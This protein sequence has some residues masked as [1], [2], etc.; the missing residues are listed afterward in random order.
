MRRS[1]LSDMPPQPTAALPGGEE[2]LNASSL[3]PRSSVA[4][5][6][7]RIKERASN[8]VVGKPPIKENGGAAPV[9]GGKPP[10]ALAKIETPPAVLTAQGKIGSLAPAEPRQ[11][12]PALE[13]VPVISPPSIFVPIGSQLLSLEV[14]LPAPAPLPPVEH[15]ST[16]DCLRELMA[17]AC[18][19]DAETAA[20]ITVF[21]RYH[22]AMQQQQ[23][24]A[25]AMATAR[26]SMNRYPP[27]PSSAVKD[28]AGSQ[29][30]AAIEGPAKVGSDA[31]ALTGSV[32]IA[33]YT[34][35]ATGS[36]QPGGL[37]LQK[38]A[39]GSTYETVRSEGVTVSAKVINQQ[40]QQHQQVDIGAAVAAAMA[41][42]SL[43]P[44]GDGTGS[45]VLSLTIPPH[46]LPSGAVR[47]AVQLSVHI[48]AALAPLLTSS[49]A[50]EAIASATGVL[51]FCIPRRDAMA[52]VPSVGP[53]ASAD[54]VT[55]LKSLLRSLASSASISE[56]ER[57]AGALATSGDSNDSISLLRSFCRVW[58][59]AQLTPA[60][61]QLRVQALVAR[62]REEGGGFEVTPPQP[63]LAPTRL[64]SGHVS[65][66]HTSANITAPA[67]YTPSSKSQLLMTSPLRGSTSI[68]SAMTPSSSNRG[69]T[70]AMAH[71][72]HV[73]E[74][75]VF[76]GTQQ[77]A[78]AHGGAASTGPYDVSGGTAGGS[79]GFST[80]VK[81]PHGSSSGARAG[82][83]LTT[84]TPVVLGSSSRPGRPMVTF[85]FTGGG[86][87]VSP[88]KGGAHGPTASAAATARVRFSANG[89]PAATTG[90]PHA[91]FSASGGPRVLARYVDGVL[92]C[93]RAGAS[94]A[95]FDRE[96]HRGV[97]QKLEAGLH[98]MSAQR[99]AEEEHMRTHT[100][101]KPAKHPKGGYWYQDICTGELLLCSCIAFVRRLITG[102]LDSRC[103]LPHGCNYT[104]LSL[105][106][107]VVFC[108]RARGAPARLRGGVPGR[109]GIRQR[110]HR[111]RHQRGVGA[112]GH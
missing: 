61:S 80:P 48:P 111:K 43:K 98:A 89:S 55:T 84:V 60:Q 44:A 64:G 103:F 56:A 100:G 109:G 81:S 99:R 68:T 7:R 3:K 71:H 46:T 15:M 67:A 59:H 57:I 87:F 52:N 105:L 33:A 66:A 8:L 30:A 94:P 69:R 77:I 47:P 91:A 1:S 42:P 2:N 35:S 85:T 14:R 25:T 70:A 21:E 6:L 76:A 23:Q 50:A 16:H 41:A 20:A 65:V 34:S 37:T 79:Y 24:R 36:S 49:S 86:S 95:S 5:Q 12:E 97:L 106:H 40:A 82:A 9:G 96:A 88:R 29:L 107:I 11:D 18:Q 10:I 51:A 28:K 4:E 101:I 32:S 110:L 78:S 31:A 104:S 73:P 90:A 27:L 72:H 83:P 53:A 102:S 93:T 63:P 45:S 74:S 13:M 19:R 92:D 112:G 62:V 38:T 26:T 17:V 108:C 22:Q 39:D 75:S 54:A 58:P